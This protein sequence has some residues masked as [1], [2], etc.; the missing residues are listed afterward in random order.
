MPARLLLLLVPAVLV[1][2]GCSKSID[3]EK[4]EGFIKKTVAQQVGAKVRSVKCPSGLTAK[5][6]E[7]FTCTVTGT[8]GSS[9]R[10]LVTEK[11]D[12]GNVNVRAPFIHV[13]DLERLI[14]SGLAKQVGSMVS[15]T[16]PEII[17]G[18]QGGTFTCDAMSGSD[19][20][21]VNVTQTD[22]KGA[23]RFKLAR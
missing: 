21:T 5:K 17:P 4:A 16:C 1:F 10:M 8:D 6:G 12:Q 18:K 22:D 20:A 14:S 13:R 7:T 19:K 2:S 11:D 23:V 9:G 15:V 3:D